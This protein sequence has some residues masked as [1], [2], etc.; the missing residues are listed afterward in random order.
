MFR[1]SRHRA[2]CE[3]EASVPAAR[4]QLVPLLVLVLEHEL[5]RGG[6]ELGGLRVHALGAVLQLRQLVAAL[7]HQHVRARHV[8][9][10]RARARAQLLQLRRGPARDVLGHCA[11]G[12]AAALADYGHTNFMLHY[13]DFASETI[14]WSLPLH[15]LTVVS[16]M[17]R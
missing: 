17:F 4:S 16:E 11:A 6:G 7:Q 14:V 2:T 13:S 8:G 12:L 9:A 10:G 15:C 3:S 1:A 5:V